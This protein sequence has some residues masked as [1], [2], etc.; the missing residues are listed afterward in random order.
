[1]G[2]QEEIL[3]KIE[4]G[5]TMCFC[6]LCINTYRHVKKDFYP[7]LDIRCVNRFV[8]VVVRKGGGGTTGNY[9]C[10]KQNDIMKRNCPC[11]TSRKAAPCILFRSKS[12]SLIM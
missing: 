3:E 9:E 10:M 6:R 5:L 7:N 12:R 2:K 11:Y 4:A 1:V 8:L